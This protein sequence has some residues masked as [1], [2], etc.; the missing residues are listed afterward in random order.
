MR[1]GLFLLMVVVALGAK[2][3]IFNFEKLRP[4]IDTSHVWKASFAAGFDM[5]KKTTQTVNVTAQAGAYYLSEKHSYIIMGD[6]GIT[7]VDQNNIFEQGYLH[8][9]TV[10]NRKSKIAYEPFIQLQYDLGKGLKRRHLVG[11]NVRI[12]FYNDTTV[13]LSMGSGFFYENENWIATETSTL[14]NEN[15]KS[16]NYVSV[17]WKINSWSSFLMT[18]YY[19]A[20]VH[21]FLNPRLIMDSNIQMNFTKNFTYDIRVETNVD[22]NPV[23][24]SGR[25]TYRVV[26]GFRYS[27]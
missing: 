24:E 5:R 8:Y 26:T 23:V 6:Y 4:N 13:T 21:R 14:L 3:Q 20:P 16:N 10:L 17:K 15:L 2:A 11:G 12:N 9:R 22:R 1:V 25:L 18:G 19:Q 7:R 27:F